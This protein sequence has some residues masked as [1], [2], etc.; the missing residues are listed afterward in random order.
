MMKPDY[1]MNIGL[2]MNNRSKEACVWNIGDFLGSQAVITKYD[3]LGG[4]KADP[5]FS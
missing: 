2:L 4:L 1:H 3:R 5:H